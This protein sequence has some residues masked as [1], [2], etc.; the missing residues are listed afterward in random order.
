MAKLLRKAV[1]A[2][3]MQ[4]LEIHDIG[5]NEGIEG[6]LGPKKKEVER[7]MQ[8]VNRTLWFETWIWAVLDINVKGQSESVKRLYWGLFQTCLEQLRKKKEEKREEK[9]REEKRREEKRREEKRREKKKEKTRKDKKRQEKTRKDKKRRKEKKKR[10]KKERKGKE[11]KEKKR[12][13]KEKKRKEKKEEKRREEK[14]RKEKRKE[15][16]R[17]EKKRKEKKRKEK[18]RKEKTTTDQQELFFGEKMRLK[19]T[20]RK[21]YCEEDTGMIAEEDNT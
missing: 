1:K 12:K 5:L 7:L 20:Q 18:K 21:E 16:K 10:K 4:L 6:H 17:K 14:K 15:K 3:L 11:R 19:R 2:T 13:R 8:Q 9:R